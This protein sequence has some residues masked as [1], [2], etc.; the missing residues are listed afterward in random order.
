MEEK[1]M[2]ENVRIL[3]EEELKPYK[4][5]LKKF[6]C[7]NSDSEQE[8]GGRNNESKFEYSLNLLKEELELLQGNVKR[9]NDPDTVVY[10]YTDEDTKRWMKDI[11]DLKEAIYVLKESEK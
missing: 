8:N 5:E 9:M 2:N 11:E 7:F 4:E 1:I 6:P 10:Y 3:T